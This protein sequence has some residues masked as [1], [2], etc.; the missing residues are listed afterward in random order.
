M[1]ALLEATMSDEQVPLDGWY[2][3]AAVVVAHITDPNERA[4]WQQWAQERASRPT[5]GRL[6][7]VQHG[8]LW[9]GEQKRCTGS[10]GRRTRTE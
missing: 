6:R 4:A 7:T 5:S 8:D 10:K 9:T 1:F 3:L 2:R